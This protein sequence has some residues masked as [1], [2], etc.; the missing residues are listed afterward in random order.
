MERRI[1]LKEFYIVLI[2]GKLRVST[3]ESTSMRSKLKRTKKTSLKEKMQTS[4]SMI[5]DGSDFRDRKSDSTDVYVT[6]PMES[7]EIKLMP[8][9][10]QLAARTNLPLKLLSLTKQILVKQSRS[11]SEQA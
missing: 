11:K 7:E 5:F 2:I 1:K 9:L 3:R 4:K 10:P 6:I 8:L